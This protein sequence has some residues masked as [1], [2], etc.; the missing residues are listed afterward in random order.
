MYTITCTFLRTDP[1]GDQLNR[2][3]VQYSFSSKPHP[4]LQKPHGNS[5]SS[6]PFV[7]T[8][9]STLQKLKEC[10]RANQLPKQAVSAVTKEKGGIVNARTIGDIP[11]NRRQV[12][13]IKRNQGE[14]GDALLSVMAMCKQSMDKD[15]EPFVRIVTS[16]PEPM[17]VMCT[18]YQLNDIQRFCTDPACFVPLS[19]DPTFNLGDFSVT[20]TSFRNLL[21]KNQTTGKHPVMIG[22]MLVHRRKLFSSYHFFA[23]SLVSLK[24]SLC[25]LKAFGTDGE[26]CLYNAFGT[27]FSHACHVRCFLH[28]RDNCKAKLQEMKV[29]NDGVVDIIQDVLGSFLKG[30]PGLVDARTSEELNSQLLCLKSKWDGIAPGFH[31][32]FVKHKLQAIESS[33]MAPIR[34]TA[35]L[36][37]PPEPFYTN[38]IESINR[39]L[40]QKSGYKSS[41]WP[42]FCK[43]A[44]ELVEDQKSELEK[45]V[46][47]IG[48]YRFC[49]EFKHLEVPIGKWSSMTK[50]QR[51]KHL[52][53]IAGLS[54][55]DA[56]LRSASKS[57]LLQTPVITNSNK[58]FSLC[59]Q[60]FVADKCSLASDVLQCMFDKAEKLVKGT[61]SICPSPGSVNAKLVESKSGSR[62]HFVT[63]NAQKRYLCDSDCAMWKCSKL[64]SHTIAC[65][66]IDGHLQ[67]FLNLSASTPNL[68]ELSK[69]GTTKNAGKKPKRKACTK[70]ATKAITSLQSDVQLS[71]QP[72][73]SMDFQSSTPPPGHP[74]LNLGPPCTSP[75]D[76]AMSQP[77]LP[78]NIEPS[79]PC[80][81]RTP[82][83]PETMSHSFG[84]CPQSLQTPLTLAVSSTAQTASSA[85]VCTG[86]SLNISQ[87][88]HISI[89]QVNTCTTTASALSSTPVCSMV[90]SPSISISQ[91]TNQVPSSSHQAAPN[92]SLPNSN[93]A[94]ASSLPANALMTLISQVLSNVNSASQSC[95][96]NPRS[97]V[98]PKYLFW[99]VFVGGNISRCQGCSGKIMRDSNGKPLPPPND[100][101]VQHKEQVLFNN[102]KTGVFQLSSEHRNVYYH[103]RLSC[104]KQ[105]FPSFIPGQHC[106]ASR[107]TCSR[108]S[109]VHKEY[110]LK[111][112]G[113]KFLE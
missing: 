29:S 53:R 75:T 92:I 46:L 22:P 38:E 87:S 39:V 43:L 69:S 20:V 7:R 16:A 84:T 85:S 9:P 97:V 99:V 28:F 8:T 23:S 59:G 11:R 101:V 67:S 76:A 94:F 61:N 25:D 105:K 26:E 1:S 3:F 102:P 65:A 50:A 78:A 36:G 110:L 19:V 33:M 89:S 30:R 113:V 41:E 88:P 91:I 63:V 106:R 34:Q 57:T 95:T 48:E 109:Q 40:K 86:T 70:S 47:S 98:D 17:C 62:P 35:G 2:A 81:T 60:T 100:L 71:Y 18:D 31:D 52:Q 56:K 24:P 111:E 55:H 14:D 77:S 49:E 15:E 73:T 107:D 82:H 42:V 74:C 112:F 68:Y 13:N 51:T 96:S 93:P 21:L 90:Q 10:R 32:W 44:K 80:V 83:P 104:V 6:K 27:Q 12:Y 64:C 54:T 4:I 37:N 5:K 108:F 45:A 79:A 66:Y 58:V 72:L 103:A